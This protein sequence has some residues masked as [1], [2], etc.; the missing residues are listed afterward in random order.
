MAEI[1]RTEDILPDE[2]DCFGEYGRHPQCKECGIKRRCQRFTKAE[3]NIS[4]RYKG[5][6]TGRG[7]EKRRD[8]Y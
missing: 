2:E 6:Y 4:I 3:K 5:K 1:R 7:K 8:R